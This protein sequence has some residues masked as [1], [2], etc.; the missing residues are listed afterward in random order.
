MIKTEFESIIRTKNKTSNRA[1]YF[2]ASL[3]VLLGLIFF[4]IMIINF[5]DQKTNLVFILPLMPILIGLYVINLIQ[6]QYAVTEISSNLNII[7]KTNLFNSTLD[8]YKVTNKTNID[9]LTI[10]SCRNKY[11]SGFDIY[12]YIDKEKYLFNVQTQ[13]IG[14]IK[15]VID[16]GLSK[17]VTN[18]LKEKI[19]AGL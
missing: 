3:I 16:F 10:I 15:G 5:K 7:D 2:F 1:N 9:D 14:S 17:R 4:S 18:R 12:I 11:F 19:K 8:S 13:D 6:K